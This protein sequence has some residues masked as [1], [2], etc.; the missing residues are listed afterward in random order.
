MKALSFGC[1]S[2]HLFFLGLIQGTQHNLS[3][4]LFRWST[5]VQ[6]HI[7]TGVFSI[8]ISLANICEEEWKLEAGK[9]LRRN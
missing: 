2:I 1:V 4:P 5:T 9:R 6:Y 7:Y 3:L 8:S